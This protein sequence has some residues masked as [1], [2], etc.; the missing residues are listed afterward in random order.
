VDN[1]RTMETHWPETCKVMEV[2]TRK[3]V[4]YDTDGMELYFTDPATSTAILP[5]VNGQYKDFIQATK[6][7][8]PSSQRGHN[9]DIVPKL[10]ELMN[11]YFLDLRRDWP[12]SARMRTIY[13]LTDGI[14]AASTD[15]SVDDFFCYQLRRLHESCQS[16]TSSNYVSQDGERKKIVRPLTVQFIQLGFDA[17]AT[18]RFK[19]L[20]E[21]FVLGGYK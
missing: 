21:Q 18:Q 9:T 19:R 13:V 7:A 10:T 20:D 4:K 2:L 8:A 11:K 16:D 14:W 12:K 15:R 3:L 1:G 6:L 5:R 17:D